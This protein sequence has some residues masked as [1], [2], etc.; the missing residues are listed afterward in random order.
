VPGVPPVIPWSR[1]IRAA[2]SEPCPHPP[3]SERDD[4]AVD[5]RA[6]PS[7]TEVRQQAGR[8]RPDTS[9]GSERAIR[10]ALATLLALGAAIRA[11]PFFGPFHL[12][13]YWD[14]T[15]QAVPAQQILGGELP[16]NA[17]HEYWG[18]LPSYV[19]A[20]VFAVAGPSSLANDVF[21]YG[22]S[23]LIFWTGWLVIRRFLGGPAALFGLAILAVPPVFL[24]RWSFTTSG[25][26][27]LLPILGNLCLLATHTFF[28]ATPGRQRTLLVLG[29]LAGLGWWT[30]PLIVVYL[31][32]FIVFSIRTGLAWQPRALLLLLTGGLLGG[33]PSW[34]YEMSHFPSTRFALHQAGGVPVAPLGERL[35]HVGGFL[36]TIVGFDANAGR[37]WI[38]TLLLV[39]VSLWAAGLVRAAIDDRPELMWLVGRRDDAGR[40]R[41]MLWIVVVTNI[42]LVLATKRTIDHYYLF[43]LYSVLPCWMGS[44]LSWLRGRSAALAGAALA[45]LLV[46][47]GWAN[48]H[49]IVGTA[50]PGARR[51]AQLERRIQPVVAW[52]E[53][54]GL[55]RVYLAE[56]PVTKK[57][58]GAIPHLQ[59]YGMTYLAGGRVLFADPWREH[60]VTHGQRVD[61]AVSPPFVAVEPE[62][63]RLREGF[64]ALGL[65]VAESEVGGL[66]ILEPTPRSTMTFTSLSRQGWSISASDNTERAGDLIDGDAATGWSSSGQRPGQ[67]VTVDLGV[68]EVLARVDLLA[69]DWQNVPAGLRVEVSADGVRWDTVSDVADYW[70]PLFFSEHH[71]FLKVRRG[72][73]Q[74]VFP[75]V[76]ARYV[77]LVQT[78]AGRRGWSARE[79]FAYAPGPPRPRAP[80][81]GEIAA[82]LRR[83]GVHFVYANHWLSARVR[84]DSRGA[85]GALDSNINVNDYSRTEPVP[86]ELLPLR[87]EPDI[88]ILLGADTDPVAVRAALAGQTVTVRE[89]AAGPYPLLVLT[90]TA[91][92]RS[93]DKA[94]WQIRASQGSGQAA[95]AIDGDRRTQWTSESPAA[96][97]LTVTLDLGR[98]YQVRA[99]EL[100]PGLPG[101]D[102]LVA[103]SLDGTA[104][105]DVAPGAWAGSLY[106]TGS[107]LLRNGGPKWAVTFPATR[108][109]F[110]R[111]APAAPL[112]EPWTIAE[113]DVLE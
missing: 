14:E 35:A 24:T 18:A 100:R 77:R 90:P 96:P 111:L 23:L 9:P 17:G 41:I 91:P 61:A 5:R 108:L 50:E 95:R 28:I 52:L 82:A 10:L 55:D 29:L 62:A 32:P 6:G 34:L 67:W 42:L 31:A 7:L 12:S 19:L 107:E 103:G 98:P 15:F 85:I 94:G 25:N 99:V 78:G 113:I 88:G 73:V 63:S 86:T 30:N 66:H 60:I 70:G 43:S 97:D 65:D 64:R 40:G 81:A 92:R 110:L 83:E 71:P 75:P 53:T 3:A 106:W 80:E 37:P 36:A 79:L 58:L 68:P 39:A 72:R 13:S 49:E 2:M 87:L 20:A 1:P 51:W 47:N 105:T 109:R 104:W 8:S 93:L 44:A 112:R 11:L 76:R 33:L 46:L 69:I 21:A 102:V 101:R 45:L 54:R 27:P 4:P 38:A 16:A 22:V 57:P 89:R 74:A 48:W 59:S 26:H 56:T 84:V